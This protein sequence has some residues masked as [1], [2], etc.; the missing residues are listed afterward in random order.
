MPTRFTA[1]TAEGREAPEQTSNTMG[2]EVGVMCLPQGP[3]GGPGA[4]SPRSAMDV[5]AFAVPRAVCSV[6]AI[7]EGLCQERDRNRR[8]REELL[9]RTSYSKDKRENDHWAMNLLR[10][11]AVL[12]ESLRCVAEQ[13]AQKT[14]ECETLRKQVDQL[15]E[16]L[17]MQKHRSRESSVGEQREDTSLSQQSAAASHQDKQRDGK[18]QVFG[19]PRLP[20]EGKTIDLD[21]LNASSSSVHEIERP[22]IVASR[23]KL[24]LSR[25]KRRP[26]KGRG[27]RTIHV[28]VATEPVV[29]TKIQPVQTT[30][31]LASEQTQLLPGPYRSLTLN[32]SRPTLNMMNAMSCGLPFVTFSPMMT[33]GFASPAGTPVFNAVWTSTQPKAFVRDSNTVREGKPSLQLQ[34]VNSDETAADQSSQERGDLNATPAST[35]ED[36]EP[37]VTSLQLVSGDGVIA[38]PHP[39][40]RESL[41]VVPPNVSGASS[42]YTFSFSVMAALQPSTLYW[43]GPTTPRAATP[44]VNLPASLGGLPGPPDERITSRFHPVFRMG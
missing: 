14:L 22:M 3:K 1:L 8:R 11:K 39:Y 2:E 25:K 21:D 36:P 43:R 32:S 4:A 41:N 38:Q 24:T 33:R 31:A 42:G 29:V 20:V 19:K 34:L 37:A 10:E 30:E 40:D 17:S 23:P 6:S 12:H 16:R 27:E 13:L 18:T 44:S 28:P 7:I 35:A 26:I 5:F 15:R 9:E